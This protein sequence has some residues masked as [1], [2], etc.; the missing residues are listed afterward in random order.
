MDACRCSYFVFLRGTRQSHFTRAPRIRPSP[1]MQHRFFECVVPPLGGR[2][3]GFWSRLPAA[4]EIFLPI[5]SSCPLSAVLLIGKRLRWAGPCR[6]V[7]I[8]W[9]EAIGAEPR[10]FWQENFIGR[11]IFRRLTSP[12]AATLPAGVIQKGSNPNVCGCCAAE[13]RVW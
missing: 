6:A 5:Q 12:L 7:G 3:D 2:I 1:V 10:N 11:K 4:W 13:A 8:G 9:V